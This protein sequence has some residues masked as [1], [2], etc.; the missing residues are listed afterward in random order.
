MVKCVGGFNDGKLYNVNLDRYKHGEYI[1][2][3]KPISVIASIGTLREYYQ[4]AVTCSYSN[5]RLA[6]ISFF[7][8]KYKHKET[9]YYLVIEEMTDFEAIELQF[10]KS[11]SDKHFEM[12]K[13]FFKVF[14]DIHS[15]PV[16]MRILPWIDIFKFREF[17]KELDIE[18]EM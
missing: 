4:E 10:T 1:A 8:Y 2:I 17:L 6:S 14:I 11:I 7:N 9:L 3:Q 5:Y 12:L 16:I 13:K 18:V 15:I